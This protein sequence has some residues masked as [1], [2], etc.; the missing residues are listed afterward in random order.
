MTPY[1]HILVCHASN[2]HKEFKCLGWFSSEGIEKK[3]DILKHLHHARSNKWNAAADALKLAKR[4][5]NSAH[6]TTS[7]AYKKHDRSYWVEGMIE[8]SRTNRARSAPEMEREDTPPACIED[9]DAVELRTELKAAGIST[10]VKSV[11]KLREMLR[12]EREKR[13]FQQST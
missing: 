9:M 2:K 11:P 12:K 6:V 4:L 5:E 8:E 13:C 7:R 10:K 1:M 3:N